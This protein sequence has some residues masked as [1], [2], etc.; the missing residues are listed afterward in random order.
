MAEAKKI[1]IGCD[2]KSCRTCGKQV[3]AMA[4]A[5]LFDQSAINGMFWFSG[6]VM[7]L[8]ETLLMRAVQLINPY[9]EEYPI[10]LFRLEP[11]GT[12]RVTAGRVADGHR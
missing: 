5:D 8:N 2:V 3:A 10:E 4:L 1:E 7:R 12:H 6:G 9:Q 11:D